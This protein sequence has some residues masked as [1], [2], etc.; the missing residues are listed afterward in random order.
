MAS[1]Q[2]YP[3]GQAPDCLVWEIVRDN[4]AHLHHAVHKRF[5]K[6]RF[7]IMAVHTPRF[8]GRSSCDEGNSAFRPAP[9]ERSRPRHLALRLQDLG[10]QGQGRPWRAPRFQHP[11]HQAQQEHGARRVPAQP[12]RP[13]QGRD[14]Q[15]AGEQ[16]GEAHPHQIR[17]QVGVNCAF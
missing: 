11:R 10:L 8:S 7:N 15:G 17:R 14:R 5:S 3:A 1:H 12:R 13:R 6:E 9:E 16:D 2:E 4:H